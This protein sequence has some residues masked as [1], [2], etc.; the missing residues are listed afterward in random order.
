MKELS[1]V[2]I[3]ELTHTCLLCKLK[4]LSSMYMTKFSSM[5]MKELSIVYMK[6]LS[7]VYMKDLS[8]VYNT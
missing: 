5:Y 6:M 4:L 3:K 7:S 1:S 8:S 2:Y